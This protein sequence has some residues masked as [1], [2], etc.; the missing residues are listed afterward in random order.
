[1]A[2][3]NINRNAYCYSAPNYIKN[4]CSLIKSRVQEQYAGMGASGTGGGGCFHA[5]R[6]AVSNYLRSLGTP[7]AMQFLRECEQN[8]FNNI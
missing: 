2:I 8:N 5:I 7:E 1:M 3:N 6:L 4:N